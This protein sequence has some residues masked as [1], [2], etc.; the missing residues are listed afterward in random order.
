MGCP[1]RDLLG[2]AVLIVGTAAPAHADWTVAAFLGGGTT[3]RTTIELSQPS[4]GVELRFEPVD[5]RGEA[6][7]SPVYHGYR[8]GYVLPRTPR[9]AIEAEFVHL[10]A[11]TDPA[12]RVSARGRVGGSAVDRVQVLGDT[13]ERFSI[14]HGV[15]FVLANLVFRQPLDRRDRVALA[16]RG[17]LGPTVPHPE[18]TIGGRS[19]ERYELGSFGWQIGAGLEVKVA[20][21][22]HAIGEYKL[23]RTRQRV[24]VADGEARTL[25]RTHHGIFG[26]GWRF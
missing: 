22:L 17:G 9:F 8:L 2:L 16:V 4:L 12:A 23:T 11:Y 26:V 18:S 21:G 15:N 20:G 3:A 6:F 5:Y 14:S 10:K 1:G 13:F 24:T 19:V 25:L 7:T